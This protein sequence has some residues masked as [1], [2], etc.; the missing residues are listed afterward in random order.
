MNQLKKYKPYEKSVKHSTEKIH[1]MCTFRKRFKWKEKNIKW[2]V[3]KT[4]QFQIRIYKIVQ[5]SRE[6][7]NSNLNKVKNKERQTQYTPTTKKLFSYYR[8]VWWVRIRTRLF[9]IL[10]RDHYYGTLPKSFKVCDLI[11]LF[12]KKCMCNKIKLIF[13]KKVENFYL[14]NLKISTPHK[15]R[16]LFK[17][18]SN[19]H[20]DTAESTEKSLKNGS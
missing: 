17:K 3:F 14:K 19:S 15:C 10:L 1:T 5:A 13:S 11:K 16:L 18:L 4:F 12:H 9:C 20:L 8:D 7:V 6:F 2:K